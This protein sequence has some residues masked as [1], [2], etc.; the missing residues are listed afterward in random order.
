MINESINQ[1]LSID[2]LEQINGSSP[3]IGV[4]FL[5]GLTVGGIYTMGV[6]YLL[7]ENREKIEATIELWSEDSDDDNK[8]RGNRNR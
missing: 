1:E 7:M 2:Q 8:S 6:G 4:A 3:A 5:V